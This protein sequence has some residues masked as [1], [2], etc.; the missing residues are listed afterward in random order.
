MHRAGAGSCQTRRSPMTRSVRLRP[1]Q[2]AALDRFVAR[3]RPDFL[4]VATPGRRQD[5]LR[6]HRRPP[7][8]WPSGPARLVVVAPTAHLKLQWAAAAGRLRPAPRPGVVGRRRRPRRATCTASSPPTS[9]W[10]RSAAALRALAAGAFVVFDELH[11]AADDRAWGDAVR[12]AF[13]ARRPP[14]GPVG[15]AVPLRHPG[16]P[17]RR[18]PRSTRPRPTTST[19]TATRCA[20]RRVVRPVYFPRIDG[21]MEWSAPDGIGH[22]ATLR[23]RPRRGP[24]QPAAAHRAV[25]RRRVAAHRAARRPTPG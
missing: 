15:H 24:G 2:K 6:P 1:W 7:R 23:R 16:H 21:Q 11:H 18:L 17:V 12:L 13:E 9:R 4:A 19:A 20:D 8:A 14:A 10:R 22:A 3:R 5:D 25:A